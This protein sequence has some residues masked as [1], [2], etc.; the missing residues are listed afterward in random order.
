MPSA[1]SMNGRV[2]AAPADAVPDDAEPHSHRSWSAFASSYAARPAERLGHAGLPPGTRLGPGGVVGAADHDRRAPLRR[3]PP[4][5]RARTPPAARRP[6]PSRARPRPGTPATRACAA[7]STCTLPS[8]PGP[9]E[10]ASMLLNPSAPW[11]VCSRWITAK[12]ALSQSTDDV[13][14][15]GERGGVELGVEHQVGPVADSAVTSP[16]GWVCARA[17]AAPQGA[18][19]S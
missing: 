13:G 1:A 3:A 4:C 18:T 10:S 7:K 8:A 9:R 5:G 12:P 2:E 16:S 11:L 15:P 6:A 17:I 19:T 14:V